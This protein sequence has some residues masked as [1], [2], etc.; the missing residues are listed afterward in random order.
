MTK[1]TPPKWAMELACKLLEA[2]PEDVWVQ[3]GNES[4]HSGPGWYASLA[5]YP[6]E[7]SIFLEPPDAMKRRAYARRETSGWS[8][9]EGDDALLF[10]FV[11]Q[12]RRLAEDTARLHGFA[13]CPSPEERA[14]KRGL[15]GV[16]GR[17]EQ[18]DSRLR[19]K[20]AQSWVRGHRDR[21]EQ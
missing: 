14:R 4:S 20:A 21:G 19:Q 7:G 11:F 8:L 18:G 9:Y 5:E 6:E 3:R 12:T 17:E 13:V 15:L 16:P 2:D 1:P 10:R